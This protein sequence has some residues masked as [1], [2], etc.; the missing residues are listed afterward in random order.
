MTGSQLVLAFS[1]LWIVGLM[2]PTSFQYRGLL[3]LLLTGVS[4]MLAIGLG[5]GAVGR[6]FS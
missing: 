5:L 3:L 2:V 6:L 1:V 4:L